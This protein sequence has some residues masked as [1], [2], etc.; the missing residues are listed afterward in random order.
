[1]KL[2]V[3]VLQSTSLSNNNFSADWNDKQNLRNL[4]ADIRIEMTSNNI[5]INKKITITSVHNILTRRSHLAKG[6]S[7]SIAFTNEL[8][9]HHSHYI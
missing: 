6:I 1:M 8:P 3:L 2:L 5:I 9:V 4:I 7:S